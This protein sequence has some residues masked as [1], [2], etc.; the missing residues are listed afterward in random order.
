MGSG[1]VRDHP[2]ECKDREHIKMWR[3]RTTNRAGGRTR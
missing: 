1:D 3:K 2:L